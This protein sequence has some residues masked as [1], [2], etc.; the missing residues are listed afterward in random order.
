MH[1][2]TYCQGRALR[3]AGQRPRPFPA[4][5]REGHQQPPQPWP[6]A[7]PCQ[8]EKKH[9]RDRGL[10]CTPGLSPA[11]LNDLKHAPPCPSGLLRQ[12]ERMVKNKSASDPSPCT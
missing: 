8:K 12:K 1:R 9:E 11:Q 2:L 7:P 3:E 4:T 6:P 5:A 10:E